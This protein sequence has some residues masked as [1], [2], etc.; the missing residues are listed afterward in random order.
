MYG[1][2][3]KMSLWK[4]DMKA[5]HTWILS[6]NLLLNVNPRSGDNIY[7]MESLSVGHKNLF[8]LVNTPTWYARECCLILGQFQTFPPQQPSWQFLLNMQKC[9]I[10]QPHCLPAQLL[11]AS[12]TT[13]SLMV[14]GMC[15]MMLSVFLRCHLHCLFTPSTLSRKDNQVQVVSVTHTRE[16]SIIGWR[17]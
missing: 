12:N 4:I 5:R 2:D 3:T 8:N 6:S 1:R 10:T 7:L 9:S 15:L 17:L 11:P 14:G 16:F 13:S